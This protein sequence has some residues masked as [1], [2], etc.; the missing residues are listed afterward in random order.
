MCFFIVLGLFLK[1]I[2]M[3]TLYGQRHCSVL[4]KDQFYFFQSDIQSKM[5]VPLTK[6]MP[7]PFLLYMCV[8]YRQL[9]CQIWTFIY[10]VDMF[11]N[12]YVR[13]NIHKFL[14]GSVPS[15]VGVISGGC[16]TATL[17]FDQ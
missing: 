7:Y 2:L 10:F 12:F 17:S 14:T 13:F 9:I 3:Y 11:V 6:C 8:P 4:P 15:S 5:R 16:A 1:T